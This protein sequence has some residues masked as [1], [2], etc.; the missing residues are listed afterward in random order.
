MNRRA[1]LIGGIAALVVLV[2]WYLLLWSP[3][4]HQL[5]AAKARTEAANL[6]ITDLNGQLQRLKVAQAQQPLKLARLSGLRAAIPDQPQLAEFILDTNTAANQAGIDF[7]S[8]APTPPGAPPP[9]APLG[10]PASINIGLSITGGY[11]QVLDF[12]NRLDAMPRVVVIDTVSLTGNPVMTVSISARMFVSGL[13]PEALTP[14][15]TVP[16]SSTTVPAGGAGVPTT[17]APGAPAG[18]TATTTSGG[19]P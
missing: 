15:T 1:L 4:N 19:Q 6:R 17:L 9:G 5:G 7:L 8:V 10:T 14:A 11:F 3:R 2:L 16:T 12:M 18:T 13:P